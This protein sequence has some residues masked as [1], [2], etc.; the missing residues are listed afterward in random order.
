MRCKACSIRWPNRGYKSTSADPADN[1][2]QIEWTRNVWDALRPFSTGGA[3]LKFLGDEG[4]DRVRAAY[5]DEKYRRLA[6]AKQ[7]YDPGNVFCFNQNI[8]P[9]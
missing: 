3:Y 5:D 2:V 9:A 4:E 1:A 7:R 6:D 8:K